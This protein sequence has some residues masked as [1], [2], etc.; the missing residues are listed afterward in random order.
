[1]KTAK[2]VVAGIGATLTALMTM[3]ATVSVAAQDDAFD[4]GEIGTLTTAAITLAL[5]VWAVW[6][7]PNAGMVDRDEAVRTGT[8]R[9]R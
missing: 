1:M 8:L 7:V 2:A 4:A 5:T 3:W 6:R 9:S